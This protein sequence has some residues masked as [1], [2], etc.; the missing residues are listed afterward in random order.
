M[1]FNPAGW[2]KNLTLRQLLLVCVTASIVCAP[3]AAY[4]DLYKYKTADGDMIITTQPRSDL[5]LVEVISSG[6]GS[7]SVSSAKTSGKKGTSGKKRKPS[8]V[9]F[10]KH[11]AWAQEA[12]AAH[13]EK[14]GTKVVDSVAN[15]SHKEREAAFDDLIREASASYNVPFPFIKAVIRVESNF[16]PH[17]ISRAGA[18]G[19]MQLMPRTARGLGVSDPYDPRQNVFGGTKLLRQLINRYD[20]DI[21]LILAAYNAGDVLVKK[22]DGIPSPGTRGY[23]ANVYKWYKI[24]SA[25]LNAS[26]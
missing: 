7:S 19:L 21:N 10:A 6:G 1:A 13:L 24:Y 4:A 25:R 11:I 26:R 14:N 20:G 12:K 22:Y 3:L 15:L 16:N 8:S 2:M 17:A 18:Q 9:R 5:T 23:V